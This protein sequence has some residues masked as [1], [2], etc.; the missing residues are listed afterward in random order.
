MFGFFTSG[1]CPVACDISSEKPRCDCTTSSGRVDAVDIG[2]SRNF[3]VKEPSSS[4]H[5][6]TFGI[7]LHLLTLRDNPSLSDSS[8]A[9]ACNF[10]QQRQLW[11][12]SAS[13]IKVGYLP[14]FKLPL[15]SKDCI[16]RICD[17]SQA[18]SDL[19]LDDSLHGS[20]L[21]PSPPIHYVPVKQ[22]GAP[23]FQ[24]YESKFRFLDSQIPPVVRPAASCIFAAAV[25]SANASTSHHQ[26]QLNSATLANSNAAIHPCSLSPARQSR[27]EKQ[28]KHPNLASARVLNQQS[29]R[30][31]A[32]DRTCADPSKYLSAPD[33]SSSKVVPDVTPGE[34]FTFA[35]RKDAL[36]APPIAA[37]HAKKSPIVATGSS[38]NVKV[39]KKSPAYE[40]LKSKL[41]SKLHTK[42]RRETQPAVDIDLLK[43]VFNRCRSSFFLC[44]VSP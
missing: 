17:A 34:L 16:S 37:D 31:K 12:T 32:S 3:I 8:L 4:K 13:D 15:L 10:F 43:I 39:A 27:A 6:H 24:S 44:A 21:L 42:F 28:G 25:S 26:A 9:F 7:Q 29:K 23:S 19:G 35:S 14:E 18:Q 41:W 38:E 33:L 22:T 20:S 30:L 1:N 2:D 11:N 5:S 40:H 36:T